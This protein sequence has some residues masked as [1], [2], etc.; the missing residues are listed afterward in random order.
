MSLE[1][2]VDKILSYQR[3]ARRWAIFHSVI[4]FLFFFVFVILP[5]IGS[6]YLFNYIKSSAASGKYDQYIEQIKAGQDQLK[7]LPTLLNKL[8]K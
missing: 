6:F 4:S 7:Q 3:S 8:P 2:K 5:I 1:E